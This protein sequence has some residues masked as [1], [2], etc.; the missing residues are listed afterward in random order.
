MRIRIAWTSH[1]APLVLIGALILLSGCVS[2][3][4]IPP[5]S[6]ERVRMVSE[7]EQELGYNHFVNANL[8]ELFGAYQDA[9]GEYD[10][11]LR[12]YPASTTI[13]TDYARLLFRLQRVDEALK[14]ALVIEPKNS[15]INLLIGDCY[16]V[17]DQID[18]AM[19]YYNKAIE[20]DPDNI[21]AY[22]YLAGFYRQTEQP[23][24]AI[25]AYY[26]LARLSDTYRIWH[27][28]GTLLGQSR[29]YPEA[30]DAFTRAIELN[31]TK[32][33]INAFLGLATTYD[34]LNSPERAEEMLQKAAEMDPYDVRV[35][36]QMLSMYMG[37]RD[38]G[39]SID[40]S[41]R[42]IALV[43]SDWLAQ[44]RHGILLYTDNRLEAA[45]SLFRGRIDFGD[46]NPLN[47]FYVGRIAYEREQIDEARVHY[48]E[49]LERDSSF[50]DGWLNLAF[51]YR[52]IDSL[53]SAI[54][55]YRLGLT[56]VRTGDGRAR[57]LFALGSVLERRGQFHDAVN[58]FKDLI[59]MDPN[60]AP[61][62][63][64]LGYM[65]ADANQQLPYALELIERAMELSPQN[66]AYID[67]F[68]WV[69]FRLGNL[70]VAL[71]QLERAA[72][73]IDSDAVIFEHLGDVYRAMGKNTEAHQYYQRAIEIDP[74]IIDI[75]EKMK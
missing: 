21:N 41:G 23:D 58:T 4:T 52:E 24:S 9:I 50:V 37:H 7:R 32:S 26:Q 54:R 53:D 16:R 64:Y 71:S 18:L 34:A 13:R 75:E 36:R 67:S 6:E 11:A 8:L 3:T 19:T 46:E 63:N 55:Y 39:K 72:A 35:F 31:D 29:R 74:K 43:P 57:L 1:A 59:A 61:A 30:R 10:K 56:H 17:G 15:E 38:I 47:Y 5:V 45:D 2:K 22:W 33:N 49:C 25:M 66:G 70:E 60:N 28:L 68:A 42:L 73:L 51:T 62:L 48:H 12:Y 14:Q 20:Q 40:A 27:E 69:M 44:R 65:L